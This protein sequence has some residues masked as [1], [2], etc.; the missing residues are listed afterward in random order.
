VSGFFQSEIVRE[1]NLPLVIYQIVV[2]GGSILPDE[3]QLLEV[4]GWFPNGTAAIGIAPYGQGRIIMSN[5][6]PNIHGDLAK[7]WRNN[8]MDEHARRWGWTEKM[9]QEGKSWDEMLPH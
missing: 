8:V 4:V 2:G 5:P 9:V 7:K 6:H 1:A 3:G